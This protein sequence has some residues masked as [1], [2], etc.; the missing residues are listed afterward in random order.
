MLKKCSDGVR[1]EF[2][3]AE[4]FDEECK[5]L[6]NDVKRLLKQ[7]KKKDQRRVDS[8]IQML[9]RCTGTSLHRR[10]ISIAKEMQHH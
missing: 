6:K 10:R 4:W 5:E 8:P 2:I 3:K 9:T 1:S 7:Y